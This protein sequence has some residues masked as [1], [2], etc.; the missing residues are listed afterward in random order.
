MKVDSKG[1][2]P[3]SGPS[4][5]SR[6]VGD[7]FRLLMAGEASGPRAASAPTPASAAA[8]LAG[9]NGLLTLQGGI[10]PEAR[11]RA[12]RKGRRLLDA[13]DR[14]QLAM[15]GEGPRAGHLAMLQNALAEGRDPSGDAGLDEVVGW[16]EVR[17]AVEAA[18]LSRDSD[19]A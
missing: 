18:K 2:P 15:L 8:S 7:G 1:L 4:G 5:A 6:A 16:A 11:G 19:V 12:L 9:V 17:V 13:L 10:D 14:L 3:T